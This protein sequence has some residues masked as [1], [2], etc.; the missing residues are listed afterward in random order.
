[1]QTSN[2][3]VG[4]LTSAY[5][6][7]CTCCIRTNASLNCPVVFYSIICFKIAVWNS[8]QEQMDVRCD[9]RK[10]MSDYCL[11]SICSPVTFVNERKAIFS[12]II[13]NYHSIIC[14]AL[15]KLDVRGKQLFFSRAW[16]FDFKVPYLNLTIH[17]Q[18]YLQET[19][20][21]ET[22]LFRKVFH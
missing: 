7:K 6:F 20:T 9:I 17:K 12:I 18:F 21:P 3:R 13:H 22:F 5:D 15:T 16:S 19:H 8:Y 1:M 11:Q 4:V 14:A 10:R 2:M